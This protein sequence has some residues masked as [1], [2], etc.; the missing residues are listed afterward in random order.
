MSERFS[1]NSPTKSCSMLCLCG[2][3]V[4]Q[5]LQDTNQYVKSELDSLEHEQ[6][7]I[8]A[9]ASLLE[10]RLRA[11]MK[12]SRLSLSPPLVVLLSSSLSME[13]ELLVTV[14]VVVE[15]EMK[16]EVVADWKILFFFL[17]GGVLGAAIYSIALV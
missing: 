10:E 4:S 12:K 14:K 16:V 13:V 3:C 2:P 8:D 5:N 6:L 11:V 9:E 1:I 17:G 7:Q 15:L